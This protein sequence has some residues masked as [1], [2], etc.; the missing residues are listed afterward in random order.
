MP[1]TAPLHS[2]RKKGITSNRGF[3]LLIAALIASVV[4]ALAVAIFSI[5]F[6]QITLS[7]MGRDSQFAFYAAD[8]GAECAL[9]LDVRYQYF[10]IRPVGAPPIPP[11]LSCAGTPIQTYPDPSDTT[12]GNIWRFHFNVSITGS[13]RCVDIWV[14]KADSPRTTIHAD[15]YNVPCGSTL[16]PDR[17]VNISNPRALQRS[18]ELHY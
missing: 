10:G 14:N 6:K 15:G 11:N 13:D 4:L 2:M 8:T 18:V 5:A 1:T 16:N 7:G 17:S 3:T 12:I 9:Y